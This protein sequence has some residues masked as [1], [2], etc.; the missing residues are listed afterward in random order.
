MLHT[1]VLRI[2]Y[3]AGFAVLALAMINAAKVL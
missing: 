3:I 1:L 2:A